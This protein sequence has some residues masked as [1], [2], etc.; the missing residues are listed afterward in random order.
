MQPIRDFLYRFML[1]QTASQEFVSASGWFV[2]LGYSE[3]VGHYYV[4]DCEK[5][6]FLSIPADNVAFVQTL[7]DPVTG[8]HASR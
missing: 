3:N 5:D 2:E 8:K 4:V 1:R 7:N 6:G